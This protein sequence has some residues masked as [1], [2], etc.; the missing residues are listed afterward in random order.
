MDLPPNCQRFYLLK[1]GFREIQGTRMANAN[2]QF[3][4]L[5]GIGVCH[6]LLLQL[7]HLFLQDQ[8]SEVDQKWSVV[9]RILAAL[10]PH[11]K[12]EIT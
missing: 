3:W 9:S 1:Y 12:E 8:I 7:Q 11:R 5:R 2:L 10:P 4:P 6:G